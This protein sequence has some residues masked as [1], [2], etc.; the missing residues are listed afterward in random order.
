MKHYEVSDEYRT[1]NET[2]D[3]QHARMLDQTQRAYQLF[4]DENMLFKCADINRIL[5]DLSFHTAEHFAYEEEYMREIGYDRLEEHIRHH[6]DFSRKIQEFTERVP[7]LSL[8]T[9]DEMLG[10]VFEYLQEWWK[11]HI[12][13]ED[14]KY[15]EFAKTHQTAAPEA[16]G[17][18]GR[19]VAAQK[20]ARERMVRYGGGRLYMRETAGHSGR[21]AERKREWKK[22]GKN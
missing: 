15:V 19:S 6:E 3:Q 8:D 20:G 22:L 11:V 17:R 13:Q 18:R 10:E 2:I 1:G 7:Q 12:T 9:Q 14:M 4:T 21:D 5:E 16:A